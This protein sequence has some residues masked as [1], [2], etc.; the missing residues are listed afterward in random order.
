VYARKDVSGDSFDEVPPT[1]ARGVTVRLMHGWITK[2]KNGQI[3]TCREMTRLAKGSR[4]TVDQQR[5][6]LCFQ[7]LAARK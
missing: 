4:R 7:L 2:A 1:P 6:H 3:A 5:D